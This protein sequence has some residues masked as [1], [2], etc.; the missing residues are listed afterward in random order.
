VSPFPRRQLLGSVQ[1][2]AP[3]LLGAHLVSAIGGR[4]VVVRLAEVEAYAGIGEDPGS[5]AHRRRTAR[6]ATMFGRP[7]L[8][9][10]YFTYGMHWCANVVVGP[11]G[12]AAAV[13][14]RAGEITTGLECARLRRPA[15]HRDRDLA[16]GPARLAAALGL[17]GA[18]DGMD[19]LDPGSP[20]RLLA[21]PALS[22]DDIASGP[23]TGVA[24]DGAATP[25][26]FHVIGDT[27]VSPYRQA[28]PQRRRP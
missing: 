10:V 13:L 5:H 1:E 3:R 17:D 15:A 27:T 22:V 8:L 7:G 25:W 2:V 26:R 9:Y 23:R 16:R 11:E 20:V 14:L 21:G 28:S 4:L 24:G 19:L 6:N 12:H 18:V